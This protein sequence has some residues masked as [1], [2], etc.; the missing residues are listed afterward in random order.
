M[1]DESNSQVAAIILIV[2]DEM[3]VAQHLALILQNMGY[4]VAGIASTGA[5]AIQLAEESNPALVLMDVNLPGEIDGI[6]ASEQ[7]RARL[8]IPV[9]FLSAY[10]EKDVLH[11]AKKTEPYGY[12]AKP[13]S[14]HILRITIE[15]ALYKYASDKRVRES[16]EKYRLVAENA[17]VGIFTTSLDGAFLQAN[18]A[19]ARMAGYENVEEFLAIGAEHLYS[20]AV[21]RRRFLNDLLEKGSVKDYEILAQKKDGTPQRVSLNAVLQKDQAGNPATILGIV[22][23][24]TERKKAEKELHESRE[25]LQIV[26]DT[27]PAAVFWKDRD[28]VYVGA[29]RTWLEAAGLNSSQEVVGKTDYDLPWAKDQAN[30][31]REHDRKVMEWGIPEYDLVEP[32]TRAD[33]TLAWAK[34]NKVPL[35]DLEGNVVGILG[36]Y[37]DITDRKRT[38]QGL[39]KSEALLKEAQRVAHIG[40]WEIESPSGTPRWSE[41]LFHIFG[42]DPARY[43]PSFAEHQQLIHPDDWDLLHESITRGTNQGIPFDI[44]FR[45]IRPDRS[46][47]WMNAKGY[48][49]GKREGEFFGMF[50]TAQDITERKQVQEALRQSEERYRAVFD[51][52]GLGIDLVDRDGRFMQ[53][54]NAL[55]NMLGYTDRE[56]YQ[57]GFT[58]ITHPDDREISKQMLEKVMR[59]EI[60][61]YRLE[62]RYIKKDG[63]TM[64]GDLS[65]SA[66]R[67][68]N[69]EH[70]A[71]LAVITDITDR[72]E[73]E[74]ALKASHQ[75][76]AAYSATLET[77]VKERTNE[78]EQSRADLKIYS[79][80]LEKAN[81]ALKVI[82]GGIGEQ[83]KEVETK[84]AQNLNLTV[85]PLLDQLKSQQLPDTA[86]FLLQS[87][88]FSLSNM[89][90][91]FEFNI[92]K[93][94]QLLTPREMRICE[95][96]RSGLSSKQIAKVLNISPQTVLVHRK[97]IRKKLSIA[98]SRSNLASF[99]KANF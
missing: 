72:K 15:T 1:S 31:Y 68:A 84:I 30:S 43:E 83:K 70:I 73:A 98:K 18:P 9:V 20:N 63:S 22:E 88:E 8:D 41:E 42:L 50:G 85:K 62:K 51:N 33:D 78:L 2:E 49:N 34:T 89:F 36:T 57:L 28:S 44:E 94:G 55:I 79:E 59:R 39:R 38:E 93:D 5:L 21:D 58:D 7:I 37:E 16:E 71:T 26:L 80:S 97:N 91:S 40:H 35:R 69:G 46:I 87:I 52:A 95:M 53:V 4:Q 65:V 25:R 74:E 11:R 12:I 47:R 76:L 60:S 23:D 81:E 17:N 32:Y 3:I 67:N 82:I 75:A 14:P 6:E 90:S 96:I 29:N 45:L 27:I 86:A 56:F 10:D 48:P 24:I 54:N 61:T 77:R 64:W 19:V 99:L 92:V 66:I 13:F